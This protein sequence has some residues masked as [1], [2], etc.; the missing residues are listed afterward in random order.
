MALEAYKQL[1]QDTV[2][3]VRQDGTRYEDIIANVQR[4][5]ISIIADSVVVEEGDSIERQIPGGKVERYTV[6][7]AGYTNEFH[8]IPAR[9]V[10]DV[11]KE[12]AIPRAAPTPSQVFNLNGPN[13]RINNNSIDA[14][15][16]SVSMSSTQVF[17]ELRRAVNGAGM[18]ADQ[19]EELLTAIAE[20]ETACGTPGFL[21]RYQAFMQ[22]AANHIT[23]IAPFL[24]ALSQ[25]LS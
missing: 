10:M 16:N 3:I 17:T 4:N 5:R 8:G 19:R 12:T 9:Y 7:D 21:S 1:M 15:V 2:T 18:E 24:P 25:L 6:L 14:S 23:V 13:S 20:M 22:A 11:R